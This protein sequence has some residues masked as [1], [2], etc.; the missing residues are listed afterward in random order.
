MEYDDKDLHFK[1]VTYSADKMLLR[2]RKMIVEHPFG[3]IKRSMDSAY[4]LLKGIEKV[5]GEFAFTFLAYNL[6]RAINIHGVPKLMRA[7][8]G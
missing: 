3:T 1:Q 8:M 2:K 6:K 4:C 7:I 5:T